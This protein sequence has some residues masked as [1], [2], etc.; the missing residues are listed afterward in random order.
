LRTTGTVDALFAASAAGLLADADARTLVRSWRM[1]TRTRNAIM[2]VRGKADDQLPAPGPALI[3]IGRAL[4]YPADFEPGQLDDD[5]R[6]TARRA[7]AVV[8][9]VFYAD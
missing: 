3:P 1:A 4:G 6:R 5:Y 8:E 7:R 2:L 9:R